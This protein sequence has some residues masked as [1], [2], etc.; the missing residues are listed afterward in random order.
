MAPTP[1]GGLLLVCSAG[2]I[3]GTIG[4]AVVLAEDRSDLSPPTISALRAV[5]G[6]ATLWLAA[7]VLRRLPDCRQVLHRRW[8]RVVLVGLLTAAFQLLFFVA[9]VITGVSVTT[10]VC[11]GFAP[12][13]LL[14]LGS[15]ERRRLPARS[16]V[17]TV[18]TAVL[19]LVL[20]SATTPGGSSSP[21]A[22]LG[23]LAALGSGAAYA[24]SADIGVPLSQDHDALAVSTLTITVAAV[25][26]V[27]I[28]LVVASVRDESI[29]GVGLTAWLLV[30]HLGVVTMAVAYVLLFAGLRTTPSGAAVVATLLEPVTAVL[31]AVLFLG[32]RL[33][34][35][36]VAGSLLILTAI[37][38]L[39]RGSGEPAD[40]LPR[41]P[42]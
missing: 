18:A 26:L 35:L 7:L 32:E 16:E 21:Y 29:S 4:P 5:A 38:T 37:A 30:L 3:W 40:A 24:M 34:T 11:L 15:V 12:V 20:V 2:V 19:G 41:T 22:V 17:V 1:W 42:Q 25:L 14:V 27:P 10:V 23:L 13:L 31:I 6:L 9:V 8:R 33:T 36:G 28:G 39:G